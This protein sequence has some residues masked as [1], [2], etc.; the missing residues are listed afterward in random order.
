MES[1]R[2]CGQSPRQVAKLGKEQLET[3]AFADELLRS[4]RQNS[5]VGNGTA[6]G[7]RAPGSS[8]HLLPGHLEASV[9]ISKTRTTEIESF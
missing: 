4:E 9:S 3:I 7:V 5:V 8:A 1:M 2:Q 6:S